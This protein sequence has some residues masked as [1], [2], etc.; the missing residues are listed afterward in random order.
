M[1]LLPLA[2]SHGRDSEESRAELDRTEAFQC[3]KDRRNLKWQ[4]INLTREQRPLFA[5]R[6]AISLE[7]R[8]AGESFLLAGIGNRAGNEQKGIDAIPGTLLSREFC[9]KPET[10]L[11]SLR[12]N[13]Y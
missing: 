13:I 5:S 7:L 2:Y 3:F 9:R 1:A 8:A 4:I 10:E 11:A 6:G 12:A